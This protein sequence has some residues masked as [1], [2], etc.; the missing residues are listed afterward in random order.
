MQRGE[1]Q[2]PAPNKK[3]PLART[4]KRPPRRPRRRKLCGIFR[5]KR[6]PRSVKK[7]PKAQKGSANAKPDEL[8]TQHEGTEK[9]EGETKLAPVFP[10]LRRFEFFLI[11]LSLGERYSARPCGLF[12]HRISL[13]HE[14]LFAKAVH[15]C[16][17]PQPSRR[18]GDE[19]EG[20]VEGTNDK[21]KGIP[22]GCEL[23]ELRAHDLGSHGA[24]GAGRLI[25]IARVAFEGPPSLFP[26]LGMH[27]P[28]RNG[29]FAAAG[30]GPSETG[31]SERA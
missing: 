24:S 17:H 5:K 16:P 27:W 21:M 9:T 19:R 28:R 6:K 14:L 3:R 31:G 22:S 11:G 8:R 20:R 30:A 29:D 1:L 7:G 25:H 4:S 2:C 15:K 10:A 12:R 18:C 23:P 26:T 13:R